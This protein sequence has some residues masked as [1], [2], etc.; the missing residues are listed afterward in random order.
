[1]CRRWI[2]APVRPPLGRLTSSGHAPAVRTSPSTR[3]IPL[4]I[5]L[6]IPPRLPEVRD[7]SR[8]AHGAFYST[9]SLPGRVYTTLGGKG[10]N[11]DVYL[12]ACKNPARLLARGRARGCSW[13][14]PCIA[15]V[16]VLYVYDFDIL[17]SVRARGRRASRRLQ[18]ACSKYE[19]GARKLLV[20][21][22][23]IPTAECGSEAG[24]CIGDSGCDL[25]RFCP[26][27]SV[28]ASLFHLRSMCAVAA[29][30]TARAV[31]SSPCSRARP[32]PQ[33]G[34]SRRRYEKHPSE[35]SI[36]ENG[37]RPTRWRGVGQADEGGIHGAHP[38]APRAA[39]FA[40]LPATASCALSTPDVRASGNRTRAQY[41]KVNKEAGNEWFTIESNKTGTR[42]TGK[43]WYVHEMLKYEFDLEFDMP[44]GY[45]QV[46]AWR[47]A[48]DAARRPH[49]VAALPSERAHRRTV[50]PLR[51]CHRSSR[52]PSWMG[53][54][55][56][57]TEAAR[58]AWTPTSGRCGRGTRPSSA[59]RMRWRSGCARHRPPA[60]A[61]QRA[62]FPS[63]PC[64]YASLS[65]RPTWSAPSF[66]A[67]ARHPD[68]TVARRGD[69]V[70][71]GKW[72]TGTPGQQEGV[73]REAG[74]D[75]A[76]RDGRVLHTPP[77]RRLSRLG[78]AGALRWSVAASLPSLCQSW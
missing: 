72:A 44:V 25:L 24:A 60:L 31:C 34:G 67:R 48:N 11:S 36:A 33:V 6:S 53:R 75:A 73:A 52:C 46:R 62:L 13:L 1:M 37:S 39:S 5:L 29:T 63:P 59:W 65:R 18:H 42:W 51:R 4:G 64:M 17:R 26:T 41:Q 45:P 69:S 78:H 71:G 38:G 23:M 21:I 57:C 8:P 14:E 50:A 22:L 77:S 12:I 54:R 74:K 32:P 56:R 3:G 70:A 76:V 49:A 28:S 15:Y 9:R 30:P 16:Q 10:L 68:G 58:S 27:T 35:T 2:S 55:R 19:T 40:R 7:R 47:R 66:C 61:G 20:G 43:V